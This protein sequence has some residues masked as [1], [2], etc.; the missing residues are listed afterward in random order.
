[1]TSP[2]L[3]DAQLDEHRQVAQENTDIGGA[4]AS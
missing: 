1:M 2:D 4:D 3:A